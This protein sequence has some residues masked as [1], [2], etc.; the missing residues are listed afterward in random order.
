MKNL[1]SSCRKKLRLKSLYHRVA[2][3]VPQ[4]LLDSSGSYMCLKVS[5]SKR[6]LP[7]QLGYQLSAVRWSATFLTSFIS[8]SRK[9]ISRK[10]QRWGSIPSGQN[11]EH[12]DPKVPGLGAS[13]EPWWLPWCTQFYHIYLG[14]ACA[15]PKRGHCCCAGFAFSRDLMPS[16]FSSNGPHTLE[17]HHSGWNK[18]QERGRC[19]RP[20]DACWPSGWW[21]PPPQRS[22]CDTSGTSRLIGNRELSSKNGGGGRWLRMWFQRLW[23]EKR[24]EALRTGIRG[25][26][27]S[28]HE[29]AIRSMGP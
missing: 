11:P 29:A 15:H 12:G 3:G 18:S 14:T 16:G 26:V 9:W 27:L 20:T 17:L 23:L 21:Q 4:K 10:S 8:W 13:P 25:C 1:P 19:R 7:A 6:Y 24:L 2:R 5:L 22:H 28:K